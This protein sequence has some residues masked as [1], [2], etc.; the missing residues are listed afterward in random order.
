M[1]LAAT[2]QLVNENFRIALS[3]LDES[4][5]ECCQCGR[6]YSSL[7]HLFSHT[8]ICQPT[9]QGIFYSV[10]KNNSDT[11]YIRSKSKKKK[12]FTEK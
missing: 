10:W 3:C 12:A 5:F 11:T 6:T 7:K 9:Y 8:A 4:L 1:I 2:D